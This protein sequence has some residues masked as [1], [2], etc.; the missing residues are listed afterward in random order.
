MSPG[1]FYF[2]T[3]LKKLGHKIMHGKT[4]WKPRITEIIKLSSGFASKEGLTAAPLPLEPAAA[5]TNML[6]HVGLWAMN[7]K[8]NPSWKTKVSKS[9]WIKPSYNSCSISMRQNT[10]AYFLGYHLFIHRIRETFFLSFSSLF[11]FLLHCFNYIHEVNAVKNNWI[12]RS[13]QH[14]YTM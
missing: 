14:G 10:Y 7:I 1:Y 3:M 6:T 5:R 4:I 2:L 13:L 12:I 11:F 9:A 8:P